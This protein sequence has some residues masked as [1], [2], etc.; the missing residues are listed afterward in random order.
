MKIYSTFTSAF[1]CPLMLMLWASKWH[2]FNPKR[3]VLLC[4]D[5]R[6]PLW[7]K[8]SLSV[9]NNTN[10]KILLMFTCSLQESP[11]EEAYPR[12]RQ[13]HFQRWWGQR[14]L[15]L[16]PVP[17]LCPLEHATPQ[18]TNSPGGWTKPQAAACLR[19]R[20]RPRGGQREPNSSPEAPQ[21]G[22]GLRD[23]V[24]VQTTPPAG[25]W[26]RLQPDQVR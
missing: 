2:N 18:G 26:Q 17:W 19:R 20:L 4:C 3:S 1:C 23:R 21:G 25:P 16:T 13:H 15:P 12:E 14:W 9:L 10:F 7:G 24:G 5:N 11:C 22:A 8:T 6:E